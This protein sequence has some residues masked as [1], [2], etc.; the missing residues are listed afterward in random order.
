MGFVLG[1][2]AYSQSPQGGGAETRGVAAQPRRQPRRFDVGSDRTT[3]REEI[4][5][6]RKDSTMAKKKT[7]G[8]AVVES[9]AKAVATTNGSALQM[10][11]APAEVLYAA[12][13]D[14]LIKADK[15]E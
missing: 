11:R 6:P 15:Y 12:E 8:D 5:P 9:E 13:I 1:R 7:D 3:E 14:A 10:L 4:G 2:P